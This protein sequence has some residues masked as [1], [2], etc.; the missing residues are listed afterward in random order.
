MRIRE[1]VAVIGGGRRRKRDEKS[2]TTPCWCVGK[3]EWI[4]ECAW[5]AVTFG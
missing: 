5:R 1:R 3:R 2:E 4:A